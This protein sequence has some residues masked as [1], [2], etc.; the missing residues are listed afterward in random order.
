MIS[1]LAEIRF[2]LSRVS[3]EAMRTFSCFVTEAG[4]S[5]PTLALIIAATEDR[6]REL[7]RRE[8]RDA[9]RPISIELCEGATLLWT[10]AA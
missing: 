5:T 6:A 4:C 2:E 3:G 8:M 10:E 1:A 9:R 7:A